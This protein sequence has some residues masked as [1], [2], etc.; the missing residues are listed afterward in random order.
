M[1]LAIPMQIVEIEGLTGVAEVDGRMYI[2]DLNEALGLS[3]PEDQDYDT[4][5]GFVFS[6]L[7]Y[8]P[9]AGEVLQADGAKFTVLAA[10]ARKI[11][12]LRVESVGE[13]ERA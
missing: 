8:I 11:T 1:C 9:A 12:R 7:G 5:A 2:D 6:A 4:V 3:I 10:D 13:T